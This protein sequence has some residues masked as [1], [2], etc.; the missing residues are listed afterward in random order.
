MSWNSR[1]V[2]VFKC[3]HSNSLLDCATASDTECREAD[4]FLQDML[5]QGKASVP[6]LVTWAL[7]CNHLKIERFLEVTKEFF[8]KMLQHNNGVPAYENIM[9]FHEIEQRESCNVYQI[10]WNN[11]DGVVAVETGNYPFTWGVW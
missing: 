11:S 8:G 2:V 7:D 10:G 9:I 3:K 5:E 4:A 1:L 6:L